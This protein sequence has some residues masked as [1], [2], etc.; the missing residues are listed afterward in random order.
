MTLAAVLA[1]C[2]GFEQPP[3]DAPINAA[4]W[5][6]AP[7]RPVPPII[8]AA[9]A[10]F[11]RHNVE[12]IV[13]ARAGAVSLASTSAAIR[14]ALDQARETQQRVVLFVTGVPSAGKTLCGLNACFGAAEDILRATFLTGNPSLVHVLREALV[15]DAVRG[16]MERRVARQ[17]MDGVIQ[18]CPGFATATLRTGIRRRNAWW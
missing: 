15:R 9:R 12:D 6:A 1:A 4:K 18:A 13:D 17:R 10:L 14:E 16:G 2:A 7:Y 8:D 3:I 5:Q 11:A